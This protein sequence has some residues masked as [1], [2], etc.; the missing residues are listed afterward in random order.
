MVSRIKS[1][2]RRGGAPVARSST[3]N[4]AGCCRHTSS[5]S[6][7]PEARSHRCTLTAYCRGRGGGIDRPVPQETACGPARRSA[8]AGSGGGQNAA[9]HQSTGAR[10]GAVSAGAGRHAGPAGAS[11]QHECSFWSRL[12]EGR[13]GIGLLSDAATRA[14][15]VEPLAA[16]TSTR[17]NGVAARSPERFS[18]FSGEW[19]VG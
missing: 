6:V 3:G 19:E 14:A 18:F 13:L 2:R 10:R 5:A 8:Y 4:H 9:Q 7:P 12:G 1:W 15:L 11:W 17:T 16:C